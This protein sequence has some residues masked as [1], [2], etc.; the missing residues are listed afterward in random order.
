MR[1]N[2]ILWWEK[3]FIK[4]NTTRKS[5]ICKWAGRVALNSVH[6]GNKPKFYHF[7]V[8]EQGG[9][10]VISLYL[11]FLVYKYAL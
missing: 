4:Y 3:Q 2:E 11:T 1:V 7:C 10:S 6:F 9:E 8:M 5:S